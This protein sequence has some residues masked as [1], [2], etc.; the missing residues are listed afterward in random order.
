LFEAWFNVMQELSANTVNTLQS[1]ALQAHRGAMATVPTQPAPLLAPADALHILAVN[2]AVIAVDKPSGLPS[3]P[4][5]TPALVDCAWSRVRAL[6]PDALVVHRL[7]MATSGLMLFAR[8][9]LAQRALSLAFEQRRVHKRY[10]AVVHGLMHD[11]SY[12]VD[13]PLAA[14]WPNRPRQ[15]VDH[16]GGK[17][18]IT[19]VQVLSRDTHRNTTRV[20]LTPVT[21]R[22]HQLRVHL[23]ALG[24]AIVGDTLYGDAVAH[25]APGTQPTPQRMHLHAQRIE[26]PHPQPHPAAPA[27]CIYSSEVPF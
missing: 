20:A 14:D 25:E 2:D 13:L 10:V 18:A 3:V 16:A 9:L 26:C 4:G 6:H 23:L 22:S 19:H 17:P 12:T 5:R 7:D 21:G 8:G 11:N 24:H 15:H 1:V 27:T